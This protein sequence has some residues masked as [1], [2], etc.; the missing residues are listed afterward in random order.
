M[1][2][3]EQQFRDTARRLGRLYEQLHELKHARPKPPEVRVMKPA[4]GPQSPGNW[5]FVATYIDQ[6]QKLR[7]VAFNALG[8]IGVRI[9]DNDAAAPRLC[10]LLAFHAQAA[11]ELNWA[12]DL[13][14]ELLNQVRIID[15]RCN[16]PQPNIIAKQPEPRHGA[17][18]TARQLRARGI[19]TTADTIRGWARSGHITRATMPNG[20]SGYLLTEALNHA[21]KGQS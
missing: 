11:S 2:V 12:N 8:D 7:E 20:R 19:P 18:H 21:K 17:E 5:L 14:D 3:D 4:P 15:R 16:P 9:H 1:S 6:E 13:H 10:Q